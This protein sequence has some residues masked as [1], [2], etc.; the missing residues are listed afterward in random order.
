MLQLSHGDIWSFSYWQSIVSLH[1]FARVSWISPGAFLSLQE[2]YTV[3][4]CQGGEKQQHCNVECVFLYWPQHVVPKEKQSLYRM[5]HFMFLDLQDVTRRHAARLIYCVH[6]NLGSLA[7]MSVGTIFTSLAIQAIRTLGKVYGKKSSHRAFSFARQSLL[8]SVVSQQFSYQGPLFIQHCSEL[9]FE[10]IQ[11]PRLK[12]IQL[13][14]R[15]CSHFHALMV[16][17]VII[18]RKLINDLFYTAVCPI[19]YQLI[20]L[21]EKK[22]FQ[23]E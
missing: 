21:E 13:S 15:V 14:C 17:T 6:T 22:M 20:Q 9:P 7:S 19:G 8:R 1:S 2:K 11:A 5:S 3:R 18:R 4:Q 12:N 10:D 23:I 16:V